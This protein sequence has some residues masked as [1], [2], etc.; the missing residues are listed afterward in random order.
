MPE[1]WQKKK[2]NFKVTLLGEASVY[3]YRPKGELSA[4]RV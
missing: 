1:A 4:Y 2:N 3:M